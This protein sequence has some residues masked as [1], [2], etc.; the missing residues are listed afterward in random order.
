[1]Y[2]FFF[3]SRRRHTRYWRDWS[4]DVCSPIYAEVAGLTVKLAEDKKTAYVVNTANKFDQLQTYRFVISNI[5]TV[6]GEKVEKTELTAK[7]SDNS[8]P[9][10]VDVKATSPKTLVVKFSEPVKGLPN[11]AGVTEKIQIDGIN[12]YLAAAVDTTK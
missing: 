3:S 7:S 12:A 2:W 11:A 9:T 8:F 10:V 4:S 6:E 1:M 5:A